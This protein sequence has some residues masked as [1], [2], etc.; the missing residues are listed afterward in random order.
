MLVENNGHRIDIS[1]NAYK[2]M[3]KRLGYTEVKAKVEKEPV[4][5]EEKESKN[6]GKK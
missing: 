4:K 1:P 5:E 2:S 6:K 3:Y